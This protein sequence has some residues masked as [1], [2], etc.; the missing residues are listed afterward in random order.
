MFQTRENVK[1]VN[2]AGCNG[3]SGRYTLRTTLILGGSQVIRSERIWY[4][5]L[6]IARRLLWCQFVRL[7]QSL[8]S[9]HTAALTVAWAATM[10]VMPV[11]MPVVTQV[12]TSAVEGRC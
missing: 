9:I 7:W 10:V 4:L 5:E 3:C 8:R 12:A 2:F 6:G 11:V 1:L